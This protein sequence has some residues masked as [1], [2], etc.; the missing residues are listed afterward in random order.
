MT[1]AYQQL[2]RPSAVHILGINIGF[3]DQPHMNTEVTNSH[4]EVHEHRSHRHQA[5]ILGEQ[6]ASK[7]QCADKAN[8]AVEKP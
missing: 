5:K 6:Q 3:L 7:D 4:K 1:N 8:A 2:Q